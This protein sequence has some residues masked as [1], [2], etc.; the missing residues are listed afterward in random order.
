MR[1]TV[2]EANPHYLAVDDHPVFLIGASHPGGWRPLGYLDRPLTAD[3]DRLGELVDDIGSPH[4]RGLLRLLPYTH[5]G[6]LQPWVYDPNAGVYDLDSFDPAWERRLRRYLDAAAAHGHVVSLELWDDWSITRGTGGAADP[7]GETPWDE[8]PFNPDNNRNYDEDALPRE[9]SACDAPFYATVFGDDRAV[10]VL[11]R[12]RRY[13]AYL[14]ACTDEYENVVYTV[15]NESRATLAWSRYWA[16]FVGETAEQDHLVAE[17]P[18]TDRDQGQGECDPELSPSTLFDD[19][20]Y[21]YVDCSQAL[22]AHSFGS[23]VHDIVAKTTDRVRSYDDQMER[24][25]SVK[26]LVVSKEYT[27]DEP[28]GRPVVWSKFVSGAASAR[29]HRS[30]P[31]RWDQTEATTDFQFDTIE[32][33]GTFV[34]ETGF[35]HQSPDR[36]VVQDAPADAV[37]VARSDPG[38][39]YVVLVVDGNGGDVVV[40]LA[41]G[42]YEVDWYDAGTAEYTCATPDPLLDVSAEIAPRLPV[43]DGSETQILYARRPS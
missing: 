7:A 35:W 15:S 41:R 28:D 39:S 26:P 3:I 34:A 37:T 10:P 5:G 22:S 43:P 33:L 25:G 13:V 32:A 19:D 29:F 8:H 12:Q 27:N 11:A 1:L 4:V 14:V 30:Q 17:M 20:Q 6:A 2:F 38:S 23:A 24:S 16:T 36:T 9:T 18:S 21:D 31:E 42:T 40:S